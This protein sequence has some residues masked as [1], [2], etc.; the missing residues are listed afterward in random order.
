VA[1]PLKLT[2][3][4]LHGHWTYDSNVCILFIVGDFVGGNVSIITLTII[5]FYRLECI[6]K[7][8]L[9]KKSTLEMLLPVLILWPV[10]F[11]F[12]TLLAIYA[13]K[14]NNHHPA[15]RNDCYIIFSFETTLLV[16]LIAYICPVALLIYFQISIFFNLKKKNKFIRPSLTNN[17]FNQKEALNRS[18]ALFFKASR[19]FLSNL[20]SNV[21]NEEAAATAQ[22]VPCRLQRCHSVDHILETTMNVRE[23]SQTQP[24]QKSSINF[25]T[26][27]ATSSS[28]ETNNNNNR[29]KLNKTIL[30]SFISEEDESINSVAAAVVAV[31]AAAGKDR[32][33]T[34]ETILM[35]NLSKSTTMGSSTSR[36]SSSQSGK[37]SANAKKKLSQQHANNKKAFR[38]LIFVSASLV[39]LWSPWIVSW[40]VQAYCNC[41]PRLYYAIVYW[42]EYLNSLLN[43]I[44]LIFG[45]HNFRKR[46]FGLIFKFQ[47]NQ[48]QRTS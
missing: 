4:S 28:V 17:F 11:S 43:S 6:R 5:S 26:S 34:N 21:V 23:V 33:S 13:V 29:N 10:V 47:I 32:C 27:S 2:S 16:D 24:K 45:N 12:W 22:D 19:N 31:V 41:L 42:L 8:Y 46:L 1:M 36:V 44:I 3:H 15:N 9:R 18:S 25:S 48:A 20:R 35:T 30:G 37:S 14:Y 39:F 7:P 38:I 40:P